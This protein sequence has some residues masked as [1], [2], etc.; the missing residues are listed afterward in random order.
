MRLGILATHPIQYHAPLFRA[1]AK[2]LDLKVYFAY[3]QTPEGQAAAGFGVAFEW[4]VP[5]LEGYDYR[6]LDNVAKKPGLGTF[7]GCNTPEIADLIARERFDA[8]L[9]TGWN[10]LSFWQAMRACWRTG[11]PLMIRG[12]S[13]LASPRRWWLRAAKE[14]LYNAFIPRFDRYLIVGERAKEYY[15]HYGASSEKMHFVPHFVDNDWFSER[16]DEARRTGPDVRAELGI[17]PDAAVVLF[18]GKFV[19]KKRPADVIAAAD[20]LLA[21]GRPVEVVLVG[22]GKLEGALRDA[23]EQATVPVHFAGFKNQSELPA[24]YVAADVIVLPSDGGETWGLVINEA[25]A[26]GLPAVVSEAAGCAPDLIDPGQTGFTFPLGDLPGLAEALERTLSLDAPA[27][28]E[29]LAAKME[30]YALETAMSGTLE[31]VRQAGAR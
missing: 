21:T 16:A 10:K 5:L 8:F 30:T 4:D 22:S 29:A 17:A 6:F 13:Q 18:V 31:A 1:L 7:H 20:R 23:A 2:H 3:E 11:T 19:S 25:M 15:V 26:C 12:D 24:Y 28:Q 14:V 27:V 9:V